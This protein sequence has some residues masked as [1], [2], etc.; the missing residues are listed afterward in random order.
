MLLQ[1]SLKQGFV[2]IARDVRFSGGVDFASNWRKTWYVDNNNGS[3]Y[4][5]GRSTFK[6]FKNLAQALSRAGAGDV[7]YLRPKSPALGAA[8]AG[9][10]YGGDSDYHIPAT[11]ANWVIPYTKYGLS[12]IGCGV[13]VGHAAHYQTYLR[14]HGSVTA[15]PTLD[16]KAPFVALENLAF[17]AG[18]STV[19]QVRTKFNDDS[20]FQSFSCSFYNLLFRLAGAAGGLVIDDAWMTT[21]IGCKFLSCLKGIVGAVNN[22]MTNKRLTIEGCQFHGL[23]SEVDCDIYHVGA[24]INIILH[25]LLFNHALPSGGSLNKYV[26]FTAAST[27]LFSKSNLGA[28]ATAVATN[29][30]LNGVGYSEVYCGPNVGLMATA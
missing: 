21:V 30:T 16:V 7:I 27:G 12:L 13:G 14:G 5:N 17:H 1:G 6:P 24:A 2:E 19:G 9:P 20:A 22:S 25:K 11:A 18:A 28:T 8:G 15:A 3:D 26:I 4:N 10:Y 29:T 23:A